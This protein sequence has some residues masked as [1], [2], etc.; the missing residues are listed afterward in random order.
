MKNV[1]EPCS[2]CE[3]WIDGVVCDN[4]ECPVAAMKREN[5]ALKARVDELELNASYDFEN[6][7]HDRIYEM[8]EC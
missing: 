2:I 7:L 3:M 8:G 6:S 1:N 4:H 5:E